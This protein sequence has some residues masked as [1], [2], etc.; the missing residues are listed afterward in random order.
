MRKKNIQRSITY[1]D[2]NLKELVI[3]VLNYS[4]WIITI[5]CV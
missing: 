5:I 4:S 2:I 3:M 1:V